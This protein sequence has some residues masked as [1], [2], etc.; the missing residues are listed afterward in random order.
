MRGLKRDCTTS[1]KVVDDGLQGRNLRRAKSLSIPV[2]SWPVAAGSMADQRLEAVDQ[3]RERAEAR[4]VESRKPG[5]AAAQTG[6]GRAHQW[7]PP[8]SI[9][10][11]TLPRKTQ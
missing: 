11:A 9:S 1:L 10:S 5:K 4:E 3:R 2:I 7:Y 6:R 8:A